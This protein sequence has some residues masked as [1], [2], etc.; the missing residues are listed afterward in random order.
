MNIEKI[1]ESSLLKETADIPSN[2]PTT[3]NTSLKQ[4]IV[5]LIEEVK[6]LRES[7]HTDYAK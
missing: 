6:Q 4:I 7:F 1:E 3:P 2:T 5:L